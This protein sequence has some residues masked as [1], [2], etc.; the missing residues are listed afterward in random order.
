M[1][2]QDRTVVGVVGDVRM[3]GLEQLSEPQVYLPDLQ[4]D[5][6]FL[7]G[8]VPK[9]LVIR[10]TSPAVLLMPE[11]RRIVREA[12]RL[13][14]ISNVQMLADVVAA[15]T[16]SRAAQLRVLEILAAIAIMLATVGIHGLLSFT[17]SRR[18]QEIGV[19]V[20]LGAKP[21][22][23]LSMFLREGLVLGLG[24]LVPGVA[25]AYAAGRGMQALLV[26]VS[27][28]DPLTVFASVALCASATIAGCLLPA[29]RASRTDPIAALRSE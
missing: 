17:V 11:I 25:I 9:D 24:G 13:Q 22:R 15:D 6:S 21:S 3:R 20:A 8:Y 1:A 4:A 23:I 5:S 29:L 28:S 19:R 10:A 7:M 18:S 12:D 16:A 2:F 26:G 14:P 27:P